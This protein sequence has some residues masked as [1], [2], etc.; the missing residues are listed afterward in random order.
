MANLADVQTRIDAAV[1]AIDAQ[2]WATADRQATGA[3]LILAGIP[4][5]IFD[6]ND[7]LRFDRQGANEILKSIK[8]QAN[9]GLAAAAG[10][11]GVAEIQYTR[12]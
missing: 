1:A 8:R 4:D 11:F 2:D 6:G 3:I 9:A 12:G 10:G 7:Q 5:S